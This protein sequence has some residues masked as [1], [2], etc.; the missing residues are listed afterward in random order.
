M[1]NKKYY[2]LSLSLTI[3]VICLFYFPDPLPADSIRK[4]A[5]CGLFYP[6]QAEQ[7]TQ[8]IE[9]YVSESETAQRD[10]NIFGLI[11]PHAGYIYSGHVAA[12]SYRQI[13]D[14]DYD[15]VILIGSSHKAMFPGASVGDFNS[16]STPLGFMPVDREIVSA[17][18]RENTIFHFYP[19]VHKPEHS[20]EVQIPFLQTV[21]KDVRIVTILTGE[22]SLEISA[23]IA[24]ILLKVTQGKK[25]LFVA[26]TDLSH[27]HGYD[28][29]VKLDRKAIDAILS[30]DPS[31]FFHSVQNRECELCG[32]GAVLTLMTL[33]R[34]AGAKEIRL[35][36]YANSGDVPAGDKKRVVGYASM[37]V[38]K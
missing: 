26:S 36:K 18:L 24:Q 12:S 8:I 35:L 38:I 17:L 34:E 3:L 6:K 9:N 25:V 4:P 33:A 30:R 23:R 21:L 32:S 29:A 22:F 11:V 16:Y 15:T 7:L 5:V 13:K 10:G 20:L 27:Y 37:M 19:K 1:K 14:G 31:R 28:Q 2:I